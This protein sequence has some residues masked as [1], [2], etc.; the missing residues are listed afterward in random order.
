M[1]DGGRWFRF[2]L[3]TMFIVVTVLGCWWGYQ[4]NWIRQRHEAIGRNENAIACPAVLG[5]A[6]W[7]LRML[8]EQGYSVLYV[9]VAPS[10]P[11]I[12]RL[13]KLFPESGIDAAGRFIKPGNYLPDKPAR[14]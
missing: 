14:P 9:P 11:V 12:A 2:S 1:I 8:G 3:R 6:P 10:D 7:S 13:R 5:K 4:L